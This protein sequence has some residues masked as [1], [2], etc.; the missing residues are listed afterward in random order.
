VS[1]LF[2]IFQK[3]NAETFKSKNRVDNV[4]RGGAG[5]GVKR[6]KI[7]KANCMNETIKKRYRV[8]ETKKWDLNKLEV[9]RFKGNIFI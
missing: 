2:F 7:A 4:C 8:F 5:G 9:H 1:E 3:Q 6:L